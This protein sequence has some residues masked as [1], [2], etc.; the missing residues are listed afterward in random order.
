[1]ASKNYRLP[2]IQQQPVNWVDGMKI[3]REHFNQVQNFV[4]DQTRDVIGMGLT[5]FN[6][7]LL[8]ASPEAAQSLELDI[9]ID[10]SGQIN[11]SLHTCRAISPEGARIEITKGN[12]KELAAYLKDM[13]AAAT[14][15]KATKSYAVVLHADLF[16]RI[17]YGTPDPSENP[18]RHPYS[19]PNY[20]LSIIPFEQLYTSSSFR[21]YLVLARINQNEGIFTVDEGYIPPCVAVQ[22]HRVLA[23]AYNQFG[24]VA[25]ELG[26]LAT[27]I[28]QKVKSEKQKTGL[29]MS[30][31]YLSENIMFFL[32]E[33]IVFYRLILSQRPPIFMVENFISLAYLIKTSFESLTDKDK[34]EL[35][36]YFQQ[37][38]EL[39]PGDFEGKILNVMRLEYD[40]MD[41]SASLKTIQEFT[42]VM[43]KLF[44]K[45]NKLKF[46]GEQQDQGIVLGE[47]IEPKKQEKK[48]GWSFLTD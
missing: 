15:D 2:E 1:M 28:I 4:Y 3:T 35:M 34:E 31:Q 47:T 39:S 29:A 25:G 40:H 22:N 44:R 10:L 7:G 18:A 17:P 42:D 12:V 8:S 36:V 11:A 38:T 37:W 45:L 48:S 21:N 23:E 9:Q 20:Q 32:T 14:A 26:A 16:N 30:V 43:M 27:S 6:Y 13:S 33:K 5:N 24:N 41:I 19:S 46:I